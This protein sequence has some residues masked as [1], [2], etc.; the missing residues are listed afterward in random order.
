M[1]IDARSVNATVKRARF[2]FTPTYLVVREPHRRI[3]SRAVWLL[4]QRPR[5]LAL[6]PRLTTGLPWTTTVMEGRSP[7]NNQARTSGPFDP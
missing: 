6:R 2:A 4:F 3:G 7:F 5:S 1:A